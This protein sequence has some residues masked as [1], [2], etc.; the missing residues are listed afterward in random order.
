MPA[1]TSPLVLSRPGGGTATHKSCLMS[2][3][4][5][6][7]A[8]GILR[9]GSDNSWREFC[10]LAGLTELRDDPCFHTNAQ[11]VLNRSA[12]GLGRQNRERS[13]NGS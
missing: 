1:N 2:L 6:G 11:R 5:V 3:F 12:R 13:H 10:E 4:K 8:S 7:M 9:V